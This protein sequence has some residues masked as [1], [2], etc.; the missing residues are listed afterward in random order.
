M[1]QILRVL[2][3]ALV[4]LMGTAAFAETYQLHSGITFGMTAEE[5]IAK[6]TERGNTFEMV[7]GRLTNTSSV[8]ILSLPASIYYDFDADGGIIRQQ[9]EKTAGQIFW[10]HWHFHSVISTLTSVSLN[11]LG[12]KS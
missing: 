5:A 3:I 6:Q 7:D 8:M 12:M 9:R 2:L 1:K 4:L 11:E 10:K